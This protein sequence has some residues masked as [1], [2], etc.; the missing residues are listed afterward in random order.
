MNQNNYDAYMQVYGSSMDVIDNVPTIRVFHET[1][2]WVVM[3][4]MVWRVVRGEEAVEV[5]WMWEV[6]F[7]FVWVS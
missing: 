5:P 6:K 4:L 7:L 3:I 1:V 2:D